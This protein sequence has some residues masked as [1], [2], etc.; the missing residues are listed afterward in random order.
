LKFTECAAQCASRTPA[1]QS[2]LLAEDHGPGWMIHSGDV[3]ANF[4]AMYI[5]MS[6]IRACGISKG[7]SGLVDLLYRLVFAQAL[8]AVAQAALQ[9]RRSVGIKSHQIP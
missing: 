6:L 5:A 3:L 1:I 7:E 2:T 4:F 9:R 8:Q